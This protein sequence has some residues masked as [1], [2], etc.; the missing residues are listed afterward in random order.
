[1]KSPS[2]SKLI[3]LGGPTGVGKST[4]LKLLKH[5]LP[6][7]AILDADDVWQVSSELAVPEN[8]SVAIANTVSVMQGYFAA[9]CEIGVL[10][11]VFARSEL[12]EPVIDALRNH[13]DS[14]HQ[15]Y[16]TA[17]PDALRR[18]L[19][20]RNDLDRLD[21][22]LGRLALIQQL[23]FPRI[24]TTNL[25]PDQVADEIARQIRLLP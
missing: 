4:T 10:G 9:G 15:I 13:A 16:L 6:R 1:L 19:G 11:W 12:Y 14:I 23:P 2:N 20:K 24:D 22:A 3:L 17:E 25:T 21:Y 8:G 7:S 5:Q 18:R